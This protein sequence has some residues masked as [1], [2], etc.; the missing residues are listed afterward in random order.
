MGSEWVEPK[1]H[2]TAG[3]RNGESGGWKSMA[4]VRDKRLENGIG[5]VHSWH[6]LAGQIHEGQSWDRDRSPL[7]TGPP[8][9][10]CGGQGLTLPPGRKAIIASTTVLSQLGHRLV[11]NKSDRKVILHTNLFHLT[12][13][14]QP[15]GSWSA[16]CLQNVTT[17]FDSEHVPVGLIY[18]FPYLVIFSSRVRMPHAYPFLTPEQKKELSDIA[19][20]IVATG[21]GILAADESTG[22]EFDDCLKIIFRLVVTSWW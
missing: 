10:L 8:A 21:K 5:H 13:G 18:M 20:R 1:Q 22:K 2:Q 11:F 9:S 7:Q 4:N 16:V 3:S 12:S 15:H 19:Q 17:L 14:H 6:I